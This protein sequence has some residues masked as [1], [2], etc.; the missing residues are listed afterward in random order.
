[1][2]A[3]VFGF[4]ACTLRL[5]P[6]AALQLTEHPAEAVAM[7]PHSASASAGC[8]APAEQL[9]DACA[10]AAAAATPAARRRGT[11]RPR[12]D[13]SVHK[14]PVARRGARC[15][16]SAARAAAAAAAAEEEAD[17]GALSD[18]ASVDGATRCGVAVAAS[19]I[20][21]RRAALPAAECGESRGC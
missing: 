3:R 19:P 1:L 6:P 10:G 8:D 2:L 14:K 11:V 21:R 13:R 5:S 17:A 7:T 15:D 20:A 9:G 12:C 18:A 4:C 16:R